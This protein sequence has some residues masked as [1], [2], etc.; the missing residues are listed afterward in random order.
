MSENESGKS[1]EQSADKCHQYERTME[2]LRAELISGEL[3]RSLDDLTGQVSR[4]RASLD[5]LNRADSLGL[6]MVYLDRQEALR[7]FMPHLKEYVKRDDSE[8]YIVGSSLKGVLAKETDFGEAMVQ[9]CPPGPKSKK[10][11]NILLT[12]PW[13][14]RLRENQEDR[15]AGDIAAEV[16]ESIRVLRERL[17]PSLVSG[18]NSQIRLYKGTPT[19]FMIATKD[20]MLLNPYP[21]EKEGYQSFCLTVRSVNEQNC[22]YHQYFEHHFREP[23]RNRHGNTLDYKYYKLIGPNPLGKPLQDGPDFFVVQDAKDFYLAIFLK[24]TPGLPMSMD[25]ASPAT[26]ASDSH[27][28]TP[29]LRLGGKFEV[30]LLRTSPNGPSVWE[31]FTPESEFYNFNQDQRRG[32]ILATHPG[33]FDEFS[34]LGVFS[35]EGIEN[36]H[37]HDP[38]QCPPDMVD[39]AL[40]LFWTPL[41]TPD[42]K[43]GV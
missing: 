13:Y 36:P 19:C 2:R 7:D 18:P 26:Q 27:L 15:S 35:A 38:A 12:H 33:R 10:V 22:I 21:Y 11:L 6:H 25:I 24:A 4:M 9:A 16:F 30:K 28:G 34:M 43:L 40:P 1:L 20:S 17:S 23:W 37:K 29:V 32:K 42:Q 5:L 3:A 39:Q 41:F 14:A 31:V 8:L